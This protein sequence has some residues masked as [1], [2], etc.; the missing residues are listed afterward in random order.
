LILTYNKYME[1]TS[2]SLVYILTHLGL[3]IFDFFRH[4]YWHG[5]LKSAN[6]FFNILERLDR[7]FAVRISIRFLFKPLYQDYSWIGYMWGFVFRAI[8]IV[9]GFIFYIVLMAIALAM[10]LV[11]AAIPLFVVYQIIVNLT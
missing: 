2:I 6:W 9:A 7:Y 1:I 10:F 8:R 5:F 3:R 11:W 4:W